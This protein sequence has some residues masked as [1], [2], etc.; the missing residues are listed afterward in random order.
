MGMCNSCDRENDIDR[1]KAAQ[2][3]VEK[4]IREVK[5]NSVASSAFFTPP[6]VAYSRSPY[7]DTTQSTVRTTTTG[8]ATTLRSFQFPSERPSES[9]RTS[10]VPRSNYDPFGIRFEQFHFGPPPDEPTAPHDSG[11]FMI[12]N[13]FSPL[14][15][16]SIHSTRLTDCDVMHWSV[17]EVVSWWCEK[18]PDEAIQ[19]APLVE[20][21][22]LRGED[23]LAMDLELLMS[24]QIDRP[25]AEHIFRKIQNLMKISHS[26]HTTT[27]TNAGRENT[28]TSTTGETQLYTD[29]EADSVPS[30]WKAGGVP[31]ETDEECESLRGPLTLL[32]PNSPRM[33]A[34]A[35]ALRAAQKAETK[36]HRIAEL[37]QQIQNLQEKLTNQQL[38]QKPKSPVGKRKSSPRGVAKG[39]RTK[40][41]SKGNSKILKRRNQEKFSVYKE[42]PVEIGRITDWSPARYDIEDNTREFLDERIPKIDHTQHYHIYKEGP[43]D[44]GRM[45]GDWKPY[46]HKRVDSGREFLAPRFDKRRNQDIVVLARKE[47]PRGTPEIVRKRSSI[48]KKRKDSQNRRSGSRKSSE[49]KSASRKNSERQ[50]SVSERSISR[51]SSYREQRS[52]SRNRCAENTISLKAAAHLTS[53]DH[54]LLKM[55]LDCGGEMVPNGI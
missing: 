37:E 14:N 33:H 49:N 39:R 25:L 15:S 50:K 26:R 2:K 43:R 16:P 11:V 54:R 47:G 6:S 51:K 34:E 36:S 38:I 7:V 18:L 9:A 5:T 4:R 1:E 55:S 30:Y 8:T 17:A 31:E 21:T 41:N 27:S 19:Y 32:P 44:I 40:K 53:A 48:S 20:D 23:L 24:F 10:E 45:T 52:A 13:T 28:I 12:P 3:V 46:K 42:G 22:Q 35:D 29:P